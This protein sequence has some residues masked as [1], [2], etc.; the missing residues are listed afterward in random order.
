VRK[1]HWIF[2]CLMMTSIFYLH[3]C[4]T[5]S[6]QQ[7]QAWHETI[8]ICF[9]KADCDAKW[10]AARRW[11]Q[12]N[13]GYKI[14][15]YA[16]DL[17]ETYNPARNDP[18]IAVSVAKNPLATSSKGDKTYSIIV[19]VW[20]NNIFG[21]IPSSNDAIMSFNK[22]VSSAQAG[23]ENCYNSILDEN[24]PKIGIFYVFSNTNKSIIK[25]ICQNSPAF[26]A[27]LQPNDVIIKVG[28]SIITERKDIE[29]VFK[30]FVFGD[31]IVVE[32][33]RD[34]IPQSYQV[35]LP[36]KDEV[37]LLMAPKNNK[38]ITL[39][40]NIEEK[41]ESLQR[42]LKKGLVTQEEYEVKRK[43]LLNGL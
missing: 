2:I 28:N 35:K 10:A 13:A 16:D 30:K 7:K 21:C 31:T 25:S 18:K 23:D 14:Q 5:V 22:Y 27:G 11:V 37:V 8:P 20:C 29:L 17:I 33:L 12:D 39:Q 24:R 32:V 19:K 3:G 6:Q 1:Q 4:A 36:S 15:I 42:L 41:L 38:D 43:Q 9:T 26:K 34:N 40:P